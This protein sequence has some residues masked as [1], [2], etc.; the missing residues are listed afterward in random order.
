MRVPSVEMVCPGLVLTFRSSQ[1]AAHAGTE[2]PPTCPPAQDPPFTSDC[3]VG[4]MA[5][6]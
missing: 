6:A 2:P 3:A 5:A 4:V 1:R